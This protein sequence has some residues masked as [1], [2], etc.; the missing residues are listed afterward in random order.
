MPLRFAGKTSQ[1]PS[2]LPPRAGRPPSV[3]PLAPG[4]P[5]LREPPGGRRIFQCVLR[6][7]PGVTGLQMMPKGIT[8]SLS[9]TSSR[10][11]KD[12]KCGWRSGPRMCRARPAGTAAS[13]Q[14]LPGDIAY[15]PIPCDE[16]ARTRRQSCLVRRRFAQD[17]ETELI[18]CTLRDE[19][20]RQWEGSL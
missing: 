18:A 17:S 15:F 9:V 12:L 19:C 2:A 20:R 16:F 5:S 13:S 14:R 4:T 3:R 10:G 11:F 7:D 6:L 1:V 8:L